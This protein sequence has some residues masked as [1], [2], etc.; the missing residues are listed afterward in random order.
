MHKLTRLRLTAAAALAAGFVLA[1]AGSADAAKARGKQ[2]QARNVELIRS[3]MGDDADA[4]GVLRVKSNKNGDTGVL[5]V[6]RLEPRTWY[7]VRDADTDE[8]LGRLRTNR[9][10]KGKLKIRQRVAAGKLKWTLPAGIEIFRTDGEL[11]LLEGDVDQRGEGEGLPAFG[12]AYY[13]G[14]DGITAA[15][16]MTSLPEGSFES[17]HLSV[18]PPRTEREPAD[19]VFEYSA[20]SFRDDEL[21]LGVESVT[22]LAGRAFEVVD[23]DN[24]VLVDGVLPELE[25]PELRMPPEFDMPGMDGLRGM[26]GLLPGMGGG[27]DMGRGN[28]MGH[29]GSMEDLFRMPAKHGSGES[30][31]GDASGDKSDASGDKN[32]G[33]VDW[34]AFD[35]DMDWGTA[36]GRGEGKPGFD[37]LPDFMDFDFDDFFMLMPP[38][39]FP[40]PEPETE[41]SD[42]VL[43]IADAKGLLTDVGNLTKVIF[44]DFEWDCPTEH[45]DRDG[46]ESEDDEAGDG[47]TGDDVRD[48]IGNVLDRILR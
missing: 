13:D 39:F 4:A 38:D 2:N 23:G 22:E 24:N 32:W 6:K 42:L 33:D 29:G 28:D 18:N 11:P 27:N 25:S 17:F 35:K 30:D 37:D 44:P 10:G 45:E 26:G 46:D 41:E 3:T 14:A 7:E 36:T 5:K 8:V 20:D 47:E 15:V 1:A 31:K 34:T 16:D 40:F 19:H 12:F 48:A 9:R 43:R 21:P